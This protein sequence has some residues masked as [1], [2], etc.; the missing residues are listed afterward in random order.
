MKTSGGFASPEIQQTY[1]RAIVV[2]LYQT[3]MRGC[4]RNNPAEHYKVICAV[5]G[6]DIIS[7]LKE[8]LPGATFHYENEEIVDALLA[9]EAESKVIEL[10]DGDP[11]RRYERLATIRKALGF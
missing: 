1:C 11:R 7:V 3:I 8:E 10:M 9:G 2:D 6:L 4:I 5:S